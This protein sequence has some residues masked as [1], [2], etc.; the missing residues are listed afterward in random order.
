MKT[1]E[2][3]RFELNESEAMEMVVNYLQLCGKHNDF[4]TEIKHIASSMETPGGVV[5]E[6]EVEG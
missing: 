3:R 1:I 2:I 6:V 4:I 5:I